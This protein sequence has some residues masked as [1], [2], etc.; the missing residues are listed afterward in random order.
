VTAN[1]SPIISLK[2]V[3]LKVGQHP[4]DLEIFENINMDILP[5]ESVVLVGPSGKGKTSLL[6]V[7]GGLETPTTGEVFWGGKPIATLSHSEK[8]KFQRRIGM[9]FQRN[10]LF[11]SMTVFENVAFPILETTTLTRDEVSLRVEKYLKAVNLFEF[12][13]HYPNQISGGMQKRLGI[14]RALALEPNI[15]LYD[16]PTA[17]LDPITSRKIAQLIL[18][19]RDKFKSTTVTV[20]NDMNRAYQ[21]SGRIIFVFDREVVQ[22]ADKKAAQKS[23]DQRIQQFIHGLAEGPL[24]Q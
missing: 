8:L 22:T 10:A 1:N 3:G 13:E 2:N 21:L 5:G 18:E 17:G 14:A 16:D 4:N 15:I 19:L 20:T 7:I 23:S 11:D 24:T 12:A 9:L 6:R